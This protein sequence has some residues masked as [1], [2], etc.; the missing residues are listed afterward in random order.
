MCALP[1]NDVLFE[2]CLQIGTARLSR[3]F[4]DAALRN[5]F[6]PT[7]QAG[8]VYAFIAAG[9]GILDRFTG[10]CYFFKSDEISANESIV[11]G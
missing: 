9:F 8:S 7:A 2:V 4:G 5:L 6:V 10:L 1:R 11:M 3:G